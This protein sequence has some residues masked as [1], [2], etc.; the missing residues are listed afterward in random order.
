MKQSKAQEKRPA[1]R[2]RLTTPR[3]RV[4]SAIRRL[5][6]MSV[7]RSRALKAAGYCCEKCGKKQSKAKGKEQKV[8]VHHRDQIN[9]WEHVIDVIFFEILCSPEHLEV[10]C[11]DCHAKEHEKGDPS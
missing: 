8:E 7:E 5:W 1:K 3:S 6:M 10:L 11:H 9:S 2:T 4:R